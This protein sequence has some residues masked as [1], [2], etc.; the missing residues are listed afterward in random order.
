MLFSDHLEARLT[1]QAA[2][3]PAHLRFPDHAEGRV[4][5]A[6]APLRKMPARPT[7]SR[8]LT[9]ALH[10]ACDDA[11]RR[12]AVEVYR[13]RAAFDAHYATPHVRKIPGDLPPP[14]PIVLGHLETMPL[15]T[16]SRG[17]LGAG[18]EFRR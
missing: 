14:R 12:V 11:N 13:D 10:Q 7:S 9:F 2:S 3:P 6:L 8:V 5:T 17:V 15:G 4:Q 18:C 1:A 16:W